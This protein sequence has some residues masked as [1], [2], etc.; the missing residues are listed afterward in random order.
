MKLPLQNYNIKKRNNEQFPLKTLNKRTS[1][2]Y[3]RIN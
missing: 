1:E 2:F 3:F